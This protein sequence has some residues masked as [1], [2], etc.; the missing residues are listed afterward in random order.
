MKERKNSLKK[1]CVILTAAVLALSLSACAL[2][3]FPPAG[4]SG[5]DS[6][7]SDGARHERLLAEVSEWVSGAETQS[8]MGLSFQSDYTYGIAQ[9]EVSSLRLCIDTVLWLRGEGENFAA[10]VGDAPFKT[11]DEIT[12][13]GP[14]SDA[15]LYFEGL[16][17]TFRGEN[18]KA[19][20]LEKKAKAN[21]LHRERDFYYLRNLPI[22]ELYRIRESVSQAEKR[23]RDAYSPRSVLLAERTG[24]EF[25][26]AYH[27]AMAEQRESDPKEA[28]QCALNALL[29]NPRAPVL[30]ASAAA[31]AMNAGDAE[32]ACDIL[33]EALRV[34]PEDAS[35][36]FACALYC[37][38]NEETDAAKGYLET[39][40]KHADPEKDG[41]LIARMDALSGKLGG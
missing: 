7:S 1:V 34:F 14:A 38:A 8:D 22:D 24:A 41:D 30:Y 31:Y 10:V 40:K 39:A 27:L 12:A 11:W 33:N 16:I 18:E 15:P 20:E 13:A 21:P 5:S 9:A 2:P 28:A 19:A 17:A 4:G 23:I 36:N 26:D 6:P 3:F 25:S 37:A 29:V 35:V 32:S